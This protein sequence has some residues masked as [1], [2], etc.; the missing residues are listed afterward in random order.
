MWYQTYTGNSFL[1]FDSG[2][3]DANR[4]L[5]FYFDT[6]LRFLARNTHLYV[7]GTFD[8]V[9]SL[10]FQLYTINSDILGFTFPCIYVFAHV[11]PIM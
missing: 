8:T 11:A 10:F 5:I 4:F 2:L 3:T 6:G 9:P 7:D 1:R